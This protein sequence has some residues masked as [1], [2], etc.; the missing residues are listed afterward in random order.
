MAS[1]LHAQSISNESVVSS[2]G[3]FSSNSSSLTWSV[4][5]IAT[6][7]IG[8]GYKL[9]QGFNQ[10]STTTSPVTSVESFSISINRFN[11]APNPATSQVTI[12]SAVTTDFE[13]S[14]YNTIG[15]AVLCN[16]KASG[17]AY[18][19]DVTAFTAGVHFIVIKTKDNQYIKSKL[20]IQ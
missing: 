17:S 5:E 4:G 16:A 9:T 6:E 13:I 10:P 7:T 8:S 20:I 3:Y 1:A 18:I 11:I 12:S 15:Q 14:V 2:G 19:M